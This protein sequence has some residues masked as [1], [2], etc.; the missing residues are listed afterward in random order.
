MKRIVPELPDLQDPPLLKGW[1]RAVSLV[2]NNAQRAINLQS[3]A[4]G[5]GNTAATET[6][7]FSYSLLANSIAFPQESLHITTAGK[8]GSSGSADKEIKLKVGSATVASFSSASLTAAGVWRLEAELQYL[9]TTQVLASATL[10]TDNT[11]YPA[12]AFFDVVSIS[13]TVLNL[14]SLT[15]KGTGANDILAY[16]MAI[17]F[18]GRPIP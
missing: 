13:T 1:K 14:I 4:S 8:F 2:C 11:S 9:S 17:A 12:A 10:I 15:G 18:R 3:N 6:T 7:L 5:V 16:F